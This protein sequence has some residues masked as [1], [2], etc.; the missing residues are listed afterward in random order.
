[1]KST[2]PSSWIVPEWPA[3]GS[4]R[5]VITTR[6]GGCSSGAY[7]SFNL[8]EQVGDDSFA[9]AANRAALQDLL[10]LPKAPAWLCQVHG[11]KVVDAS[12]VT[13]E[14]KADASYADIPGTVCAVTT[15]DCL[16]VLFCDQSGGRVAA[17]H[18]GWRGLAAGILE[19]VVRILRVSPSQLYAWLGPAIGPQRFEVG[20]EVRALFAQRYPANSSAFTPSPRGRWL[21]DIYQL[22]THHLQVVGVQRIFG[23]GFCTYTDV[24]R[25]YS[26]RRDHNTGRMASLIWVE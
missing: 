5:A 17:A 12:A 19:E 18:A 21:A 9:V 26:Y 4:V 1:M 14:I 2:I 25:F 15:A 16:P 20:E 7:E 11:N 6:D 3:P 13:G 23:G 24:Q 8:S 22:A 10:A